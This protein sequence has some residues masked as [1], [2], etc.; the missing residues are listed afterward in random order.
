MIWDGY[1]LAQ[2]TGQSS[3]LAEAIAT[4][5]AVAADLGDGTGVYADLQAENDVGEPL[6]EAMY[7]LA[8][9][10]QSFARR[11]LL[12]AA[13][14][15]AGDVTARTGAYGRFFD[16]PPQP[17]PVTAWQVNGGLALAQV[18]AALDPG[19]RPADP[20]FWAGAPFVPDNLAM[21]SSPVSFSFTGRAVAI[22]GTIG[23]DCCSDGHAQVFMDGTQTFDQTGIWQNKSSSGVSLPGSV[24]FAW[25]WPTAGR[26]TIEIDPA[27]PNA[28]QGT[29]FFHMTGYYV[30]R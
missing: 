14:A 19:G 30:V 17:A 27:V 6:I 28:K 18:A 15:S 12:D 29:S 5:Q 4:A 1:T 11:W 3:Y 9:H 2:I 7:L 23:E 21:T 10:G 24:L 25:R 13:S 26:H 20:G 8:A 22:I 16:G